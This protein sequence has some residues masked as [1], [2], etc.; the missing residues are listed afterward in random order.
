MTKD[1][2]KQLQ[3]GDRFTHPRFIGFFTIAHIET[4]YEW[5]HGPGTPGVETTISITTTDGR[6][7]KIDDPDAAQITKLP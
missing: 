2:F 3:V 4:W 6:Y 7:L 1:Q 5:P